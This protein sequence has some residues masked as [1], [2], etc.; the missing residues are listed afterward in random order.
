M[1]EDAA[2]RPTG[3]TDLERVAEIA[4]RLAESENL[5]ETLQRIVD[6][7]T[8]YIDHCDGASLMIVRRGAVTTPASTDADAH[9]ADQAQYEAGEGPCLSAMEQHETVVVDDITSDDRWPAWRDAVSELGWASMIGLR[10]FIAQDTMGALNLY[11]RRTAAF[12]VRSQSL[13]QVFASHAAVAM[14]AAIS[15]SGLH[16]ALESRDLIGQA[17]GVLMERD[18]LTGQEAFARL[19]A[20]SNDRNIKLREV[21]RQITETG[22]LPQ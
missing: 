11:S 17:K 6:L 3:P 4:R 20:V 22:E 8:G 7:A 9:A 21:A 19:V 10:L 14:K 18:R 5:D 13:A 2:E 12:D 1:S 16:R 15:E